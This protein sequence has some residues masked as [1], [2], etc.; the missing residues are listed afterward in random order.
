MPCGTLVEVCA[1]AQ[2]GLFAVVRFDAADGVALDVEV[3]DLAVRGG[4]TCTDLARPPN[5]EL[6]ES[7]VAV[8]LRIRHFEIE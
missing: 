4:S 8:S 7:D 3:R 2:P 5:D 1:L 6:F